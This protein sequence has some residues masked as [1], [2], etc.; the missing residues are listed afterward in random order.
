MRLP[1]YPTNLVR[2]RQALGEA[3][4]EGLVATTIAAGVQMKAIKPTEFERVIV[5]QHSP[6]EGHRLSDRQPA[7]GSGAGQGGSTGQTRRHL[8][9]ADLCHGR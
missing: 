8:A 1:C 7:A 4:V 6:G 2:F 5:R 9:Q 3:G